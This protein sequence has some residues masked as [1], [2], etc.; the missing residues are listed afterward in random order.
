MNRGI[1]DDLR[2][3]FF[4]SGSPAMLYIGINIFIFLVGGVIG[5]VIT[6]SGNR[7]WVAMQ[8]QEYFA[9]PG[10]LSSLPIKFYTL[11]TYQFFHAGFFHV[12]FN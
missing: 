4:K 10:D 9:F 1:V 6:L 3:K 11:L 5:V 12:L 7:G 2:L 8:I